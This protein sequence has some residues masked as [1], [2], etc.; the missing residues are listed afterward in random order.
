MKIPNKT[1]EPSITFN[2]FL[3]VE[4]PKCE[5]YLDTQSVKVWCRCNKFS[6]EW[7]LMKIVKN[8]IK[9]KELRNWQS[10]LAC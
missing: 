9:S 2:R 7:S 3:Y 1:R 8:A 6:H 5:H 4:I 10:H